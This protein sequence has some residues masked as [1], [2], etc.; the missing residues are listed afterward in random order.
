M[1]SITVQLKFNKYLFSR[2]KPQSN[3]PIAYTPNDWVGKTV[4]IIPM[5]IHTTDR[6]IE[7]QFNEETGDYELT[8]KTNQILLK[9]IK[10]ASN[11]GR[12]Y[13]PKELVGMDVLII[14]APVLDN[15]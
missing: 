4:C 7:S 15:F 5:D 3:Q 1:T 13:L 9:T 14:E 12:I 10:Q 2:V 11:I 8:A 6:Y